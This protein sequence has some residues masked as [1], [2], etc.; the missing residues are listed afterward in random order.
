MI[1]QL[2]SADFDYTNTVLLEEEP[3]IKP[4]GNSQNN[5]L[6]KIKISK[7][8]QGEIVLRTNSQ[9]DGFLMLSEIYAPGWK[10][11]VD[12]KK[13]K[14]YRANYVFRAVPME[15]GHHEVKF[16]FAPTSFKIGAFITLLSFWAILTTVGIKA[17]EYYQCRPGRDGEKE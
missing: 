10:V 11:Y 2:Q 9:E 7:Y 15:K 12:G 6:W 14:I 17:V 3:E 4:E 5:N 13:G 8:A 16:I 1:Q